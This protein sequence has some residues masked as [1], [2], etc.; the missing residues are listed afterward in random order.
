MQPP[1]SSLSPRHYHLHTFIITTSQPPSSSPLS[2]S[3]LRRHYHSHTNTTTITATATTST[4]P[5]QKG[6]VRWF[7]LHQPPKKHLRVRLTVISAE[8][9][10]FGSTF[11]SSWSVWK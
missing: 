5:S 2:L 6:Y 10:A 1:P 11:N 3:P 8:W 9:G 4:Q 7:L